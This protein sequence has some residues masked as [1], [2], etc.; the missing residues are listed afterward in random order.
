M[1]WFF[2]GGV[3]SGSGAASGVREMITSVGVEG[4]G[5]ILLLIGGV[6]ISRE[7][8]SPGGVEV[9][10]K[11][12]ASLGGVEISGDTASFRGVETLG[13]TASLGGVEISGEMVALGGVDILEGNFLDFGG[14]QAGSGRVG[15]FRLVRSLFMT[16]G[17][18]IEGMATGGELTLR[19]TEKKKKENCFIYHTRESII[20]HRR[21]FYTQ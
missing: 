3:V 11:M 17:V 9:S 15:L 13:E 8:A 19:L 18:L 14:S 5:E 12:A 16:A 20:T 21:A 7:M 6:E 1:V 4:L 2:L 10:G